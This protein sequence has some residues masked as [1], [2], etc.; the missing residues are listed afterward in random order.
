MTLTVDENTYIDEADADAYFDGSLSRDD[1][2]V[3]DTDVKERAL[4]TATR[5]LDRQKWAGTKTDPDQA[6]AWPR[7]G[8]TDRDGNE[9]DSATVPQAI[10]DA[11]AELALSL[12]LDP[13]VQTNTGTGLNTKRLKAGSA[14]IEYFR[15]TR[16][17][18]FPTII[19]ELVGLYLQGSA[20]LVVPAAYGTDETS[21][22]T[23]DVGYGVNE[24][25]N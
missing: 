7:T 20:A 19:Q 25:F 15:P 21:S 16:N 12:Y 17:A 22:F 6:L 2:S 3:L 1:W 13:Q 14:E 23:S 11:Q 10:K 18:R 4:I 8:L 24:G 9:L 5:M